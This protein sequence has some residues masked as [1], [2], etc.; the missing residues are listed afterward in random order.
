M[1]HAAL[2]VPLHRQRVC[3]CGPLLALQDVEVVVGGVSAGV[4]FCAERRSED[5]QVFGYAGVDQVH[6]AHGAAGVVEEPFG[7][8]GAYPGVDG[9]SVGEG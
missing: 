4:A 2:W 7:W 9:R 6:G 3:R 8:V 1:M 5:D